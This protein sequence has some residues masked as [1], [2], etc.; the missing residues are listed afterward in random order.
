MP[1]EVVPSHN[2]KVICL[3]ASSTWDEMTAGQSVLSFLFEASQLAVKLRYS[4]HG[5]PFWV[6]DRH[7][8]ASETSART[9]QDYQY[10]P[11]WAAIE[12]P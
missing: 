6:P 9:T 7:G 11:D 8:A 12:Q 1:W 10:I 5:L 3:L 4:P 2:L